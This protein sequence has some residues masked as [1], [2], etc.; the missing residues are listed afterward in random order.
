LLLLA[1][2]MPDELSLRDAL[3]SAPRSHNANAAL[4]ARM[5]CGIT[6]RCNC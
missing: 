1:C 6:V 3:S 5:C 4:A 2:T